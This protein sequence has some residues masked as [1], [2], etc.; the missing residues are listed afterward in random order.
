[1]HTALY[2]YI[3]FLFVCVCLHVC[4]YVQLIHEYVRVHDLHVISGMLKMDW[5]TEEHVEVMSFC[6]VIL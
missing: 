2:V 1:M 4:M 6:D 5:S 3:H